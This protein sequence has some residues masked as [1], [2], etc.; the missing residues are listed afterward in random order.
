MSLN[1]PINEHLGAERGYYVTTR[2]SSSDALHNEGLDRTSHNSGN[3]EIELKVM[4]GCL[5]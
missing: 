2:T 3:K 4:C 1:K 5:W